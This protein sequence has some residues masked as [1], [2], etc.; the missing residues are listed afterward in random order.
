MPYVQE[1]A[2]YGLFI[3][4]PLYIALGVTGLFKR[5][6]DRGTTGRGPSATLARSNIVRLTGGGSSGCSGPSRLTK[7]F[8]RYS[9]ISISFHQKEDV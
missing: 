5:K 3:L 1:A 6:A 8:V 4:G 9:P 7:E 2:I